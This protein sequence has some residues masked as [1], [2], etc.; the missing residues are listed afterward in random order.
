MIPSVVGRDLDVTRAGLGELPRQQ[1]LAAKVVGRI[2]INSVLLQS[3][4][5]FAFQTHDLRHGRLHAKRGFI[6]ADQ[7]FDAAVSTAAGQM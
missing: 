2:R 3:G 1:A 4:F 6:A 5:R 7:S